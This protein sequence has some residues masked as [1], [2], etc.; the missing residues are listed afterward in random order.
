MRP[1][2][3]DNR[4]VQELAGDPLTTNVSRQVHGALWSKVLPTAVKAPQLLSYAPE[5]AE[6]LGWSAEDM[7]SSDAAQI[8]S[9]NQLLDG[10]FT[11]ATCYGG[12]SLVIGQVN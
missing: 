4:F 8:L 9:G 12:I 1:L 3:F 5:V 6:L 10:M 2:Q 7:Q 11:F